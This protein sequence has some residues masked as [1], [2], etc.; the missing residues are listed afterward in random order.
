MKCCNGCSRRDIGCGPY[1][2]FCPQYIRE[3]AEQLARYEANARS[4]MDTDA[5]VTLHRTR[6]MR[7]RTQL[8]GRQ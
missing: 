2:K 4:S 1:R 6:V 7:R 5:V 3:H 8:G